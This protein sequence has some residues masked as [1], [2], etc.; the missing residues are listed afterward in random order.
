MM[1]AWCFS[2]RPARACPITPWMALRTFMSSGWAARQLPECARYAPMRDKLAALCGLDFLH[3][4]ARGEVY[5]RPLLAAA[6]ALAKLGAYRFQTNPEGRADHRFPSRRE[7]RDR[8][9]SVADLHPWEA[10]LPSVATA[11][12]KQFVLGELER[13]LNRHVPRLP[14][15]PP[16]VG[17]N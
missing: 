10:S 1:T 5:E 6:L 17:P 11:A 2:N 14:E 13:G 7:C 12:G 16:E 3:S 15:L 9:Q 4:Y 8:L